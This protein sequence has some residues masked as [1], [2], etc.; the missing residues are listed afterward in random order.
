MLYVASI[1]ASV[2]IGRC[3]HVVCDAC[4]LKKMPI[5]ELEFAEAVR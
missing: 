4:A 3:G 2:A 5:A 1:A